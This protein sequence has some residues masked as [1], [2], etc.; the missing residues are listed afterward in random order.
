MISK[1]EMQF[2]RCQDGH[3][4]FVEIQRKDGFYFGEEEIINWCRICGTICID[5]KIGKELFPGKILPARI[6]E[7]SKKLVV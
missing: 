5:E 4:T 7:I 6:P 1:E 3:H 2:Q